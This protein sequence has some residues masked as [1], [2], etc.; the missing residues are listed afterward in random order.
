MRRAARRLPP[1]PAACAQPTGTLDV[2]PRTELEVG[3]AFTRVRSELFDAL[4]EESASY[5]DRRNLCTSPAPRPD[6]GAEAP[7]TSGRLAR[8]AHQ[9]VVDLRAGGQREDVPDG[10]G[11]VLGAEDR[12]S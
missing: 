12:E 5:G 4:P 9:D 2:V 8:R 7:A 3:D 10:V 6:A 11:D 1:C